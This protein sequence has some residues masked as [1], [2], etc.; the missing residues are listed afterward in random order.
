MRGL[1]II[2]V[3]LGL[4]VAYL[5]AWPVPIDPQAWTPPPAPAAEGVYAY[6]DTLKGIE[7]LAEGLG[8]GPEGINVDAAGRIYA[9]YDDG[10]VVRY[11]H[12][13][14]DYTEL[15]NTG[16]RPLGITFGPTGG[17]DVADARKG[18]LHIGRGREA[19]LN[20]DSADGVPFGFTDDVDNTRLDKSLYFTDASSRFGIDATMADIF[21]HAP[22]GRL[23]R[24][25]VVNK[26]TEV[27]LDGLYFPNGVAVGPD[28]AYVLVNETT[29]YRV[30]RYWL[31]GDKAGTTDVFIDNLPGFPDNISFN[32]RNRFWLALYSPRIEQ[33][34]ALLPHP[35]LRKIVFRLPD[36]LHPKPPRHSFAL[37]LDTD[38]KVIANLQYRGDDAYSPITSVREFGPWLFFGSL[39]EPAIGRLPLHAALPAEPAPVG[40]YAL[41]P[42]KPVRIEPRPLS[43]E[44][45]EEMEREAREAASGDDE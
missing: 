34:D 20:T 18:L 41:P 11:S 13:G 28:D 7:R 25:D 17:V 37:G 10:R 12:N 40:S 39:T 43:A 19:T 2:L 35:A 21:E 42:A 5:L 45:R 4:C 26:T 31:K 23:L 24:Y 29:K 36:F 22:N 33:L 16:G 15:T 3:L 8:N 9:G 38:G 30:L 27:L 32:G 44:E 14:G 6:N 1:K